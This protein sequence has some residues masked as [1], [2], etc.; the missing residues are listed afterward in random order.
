M[1]KIKA[2]INKLRKEIENHNYKYYVLDSPDISDLEYDKLLKRLFELEEKFPEFKDPNSPTQRVGANPVDKFDKV[3]HSIPMLSL[4]N[5]TNFNEL[6][7][8]EN[9]IRKVLPEEEM[10]YIVEPKIDGL[11]VELVYENNIFVRGSTRGDGITGED[12][13]LNLKTIKSIPL[14]LECEFN[15][16]IFEVRGE[17]FITKDNFR[18]INEERSKNGLPLFANPRNCAAGSLRQLDSKET[19]KRNLDIFLYGNGLIEGIE[20]KTQWELFNLL[21][22][23]HF[24]VNTLIR[25]VTTIDEIFEYCNFIEKERDNLPYE[26]DGVV[27]KINDFHYRKILGEVSRFPKWAVAYKFSESYE[28]T[29]LKKVTVQVGRTG[30]LTPVAELEPVKIKGVTVSRATLHNFDYIKEKDIKIN[31]FVYVKRAG[32]VIPEI[33]GPV[34]E[35]RQGN[36]K[37]I[38]IPEKCPICGGKILRE[39]GE[40]NY[41]CISGLSCRAQL[42]G[43]IKHFVSN[44]CMNIKGLGEKI[45]ENFVKQEII[46]DIADIY[47]LKFE[48]LVIFPGFG[49]K[50]AGNLIKSIANSKKNTLWRLV[51]GLGIRTVGEELSKTLSKNFLNLDS[52]L[53][54]SIEEI[55][56]VI[57]KKEIKTKRKSNVIAENI[58]NFFRE[59]HNLKVIEKL[60]KAEVNFTEFELNN[61]EGGSFKDTTF[62]FTGTLSSITRK[63]AKNIVEKHGGKVLSSISP[64]LDYLVVGKNPGSKLEKARSLSIKIIDEKEFFELFELSEFS[65]F[66]ENAKQNNRGFFL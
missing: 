27:I 25:K 2:E 53:T 30:V 11:A 49:E 6:K 34:Y 57:Y 29:A 1:E 56:N 38:S 4:S 50:S 9:R 12:I 36:E 26:I 21:K 65:E 13:T 24:N 51:H 46:K 40:V 3:P 37:E 66:K 35:K 41:R 14:K 28:I 32:D 15:L 18:K 59:E 61:L 60:R 63:E 54:A 33:V 42:V 39:E 10:E 23:L 58:F 8:F 5:V 48:D 20:I 7:D 62:L 52:I 47:F 22:K 19:A 31:D 17:V 16:K 55:E 43:R 44:N 45:V 64:N